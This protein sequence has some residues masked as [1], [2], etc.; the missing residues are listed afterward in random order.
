M[1]I[2]I[3]A[4]YG[5][6]NLMS[7]RLWILGI[8]QCDICVSYEYVIVNEVFDMLPNGN[9]PH[10]KLWFEMSLVEA[11][12]WYVI[13]E[14]WIDGMRK[15]YMLIIHVRHFGYE[16]WYEMIWYWNKRYIVICMSHMA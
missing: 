11:W 6:S 13:H 2:Y 9:M 15:M 16:K 1:Y 12:T 14:V 3:K 8:W 10:M 7:M 4:C 5:Y